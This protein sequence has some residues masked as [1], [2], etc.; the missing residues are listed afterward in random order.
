MTVS[1]MAATKKWLK[2]NWFSLFAS[3]M[4]FVLSTAVNQGIDW[5]KDSQ[6]QDATKAGLI[7]E[8]EKNL[9]AILMLKNKGIE[10]KNGCEKVKVN[11]KTTQNLVRAPAIFSSEY[12]IFNSQ[13]ISE[14]DR[15]LLNEINAAYNAQQ[16]FINTIPSIYS[17]S[18]GINKDVE[19]EIY[20]LYCDY[21]NKL[22]KLH[23]QLNE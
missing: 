17:R 19:S 3:T 5:Y 14:L 21:Q 7:N 10:F 16:L 22:T 18:G 9:A 6:V 23:N 4:A 15:S 1:K 11:D 2:N 8:T 13:K 12:Y 20:T